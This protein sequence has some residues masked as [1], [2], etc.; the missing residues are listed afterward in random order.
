MDEIY[1]AEEREKE[2]MTE[3]MEKLLTQRIRSGETE[4]RW[5][6]MEIQTWRIMGWSGKD[7]GVETKIR[8]EI[9]RQNETVRLA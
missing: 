5:K 8:P 4:M 1:R 9:R 2:N 7:F 6:W 3:Q